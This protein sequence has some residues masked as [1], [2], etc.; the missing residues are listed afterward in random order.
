[1]DEIIIEVDSET[2]E[3]I[4]QIPHIA[5]TYDGIKTV[6]LDYDPYLHFVNK[7]AY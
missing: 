4:K 6:Y 1:M 5:E 2:F 3:K 7:E